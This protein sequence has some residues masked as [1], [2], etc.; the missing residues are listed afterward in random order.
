VKKLLRRMRIQVLELQECLKYCS[1][2]GPVLRDIRQ[3]ISSDGPRVGPRSI[4]RLEEVGIHSLE[5]L[6]SLTTEDLVQLG[7]RR[8]LAQQ[9]RAYATAAENKLPEP[10]ALNRVRQ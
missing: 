8:D 4:S 6:V 2:L 9:I 5:D 3:T 7:I 10:L 1:P